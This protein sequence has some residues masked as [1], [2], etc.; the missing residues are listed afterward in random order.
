MRPQT[1]RCL[2]LASLL[3]AVASFGATSAQ[4]DV[5][6]GG[7]ACDAASLTCSTGTAAL[8]AK[9]TSQFPTVID[10][11]EMS[12]GKIKVRA[13]FTI[14]PVKGDTLLGITMPTGAVIAASWNEKGFI[15]LKAVTDARA[16]GTMNVH[17]TLTPSLEASI[18][19]IG[20]NY[21]ASQLI[22]KIPGGKFNYDATATMQISPW[23]FAPSVLKGT[24]PAIDQSTIFAIPFST[25]GVSEGIVEGN[26]A[27]QAA[28]NPTFTYTTKAVR[29]DSE[30]ISTAD[31]V[32]K[33]AVGDAD[34]LDLSASV[35]GEVQLG[36][37][38]DIRPVVKVDSVAGIP[39]FGL[40]KYSFTAVSTKIGGSAAVPVQ[41]ENA[42][43]HIPLPNIKVPTATLAMGSVPSGKSAMKTVTI[44]STGELGGKL[45]I[46]SS[47]PQFTVPSGE[48]TVASKG[49]F[50]LKVS[51]RPTGDQPSSAT[52]TVKSN[53]PG[54]PEQT[55]KV[56]AN[57]APGADGE[58]DGE[59]G[60]M[61]GPQ[62]NSGC[63]VA[64]TGSSNRTAGTFGLLGLGLGLAAVV[65]RRRSV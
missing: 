16:L 64:S 40:V 54:E 53:D 26:L 55:F 9:I 29:L 10:S 49:K 13:R 57:G 41:F 46:T 50:D 22:N 63:S 14:D 20:I 21:N 58:A 42:T 2:G 27:I 48:Q 65:R 43:I 52:I 15:N 18:Y 11:G 31:G 44:D 28:A 1:I 7:A 36:G 61:T 47:D 39:T 8:N 30:T 24:M 62:E 37:T 17:Y 38:L 3:G 19:G 45:T 59:S 25:L 12:S 34:F 60:G 56:A 4:A 32:A 23:G 33:L 6:G 35:S 51:F 5:S